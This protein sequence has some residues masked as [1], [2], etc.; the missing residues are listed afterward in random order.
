MEANPDTPSESKKM[1]ATQWGGVILLY[2][3]IPLIL[4]VCNGS[5]AWWQGWGFSI[6]IFLAGVGTRVGTEI[7]FPG[8][9]AERLKWGKGRAVMDWDRVLAPLMAISIS[10]PLIIVAGLDHRF[11][12]TAA[13]PLWVNLLGLALIL[14]GYAISSWAMLENRYFSS[15]VYI[16]MDRGHTVCDTGPYRF[17]RH[18]SYAGNAM[19][20][21]GIVL[22]LNS[23]WTIIPVVFAL[24]V[25]LIRTTLE[26]GT[27]F[28][29]LPGY[30]E[31]THRVIYRLV[32]GIW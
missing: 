8:L 1:T 3:F 28:K 23:L 17:V 13:F 32:P 14:F 25:T 20:M 7:R 2:L 30:Q 22:S 6:L 10:F 12:W 11:G 29:E 26:D 5:M 16:Q 21:I 9:M 19:A 31:Y 24:V 18:P 27:L 4:F 15:E